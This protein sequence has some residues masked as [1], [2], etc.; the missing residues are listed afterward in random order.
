VIWIV[1][2]QT[3]DLIRKMADV[4]LR[5]GGVANLGPVQHELDMLDESKGR[6]LETP[7]PAAPP[8]QT[9]PEDK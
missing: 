5:T 8:P 9:E 2:E 3:A 6:Q 4:T 7:A 1:D